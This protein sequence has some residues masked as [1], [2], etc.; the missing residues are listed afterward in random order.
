M[1]GVS[2][3]LEGV[4]QQS[5]LFNEPEQPKP[6]YKPH[7]AD[8]DELIEEM[9]EMSLNMRRLENRLVLLRAKVEGLETI[10]KP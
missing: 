2:Q 7:A 9:N 1:N 3:I 4:R 8:F 5:R 6:T 10:Q